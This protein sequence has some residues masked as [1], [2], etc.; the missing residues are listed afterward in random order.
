[1]AGRVQIIGA[2][3]ALA[4]FTICFYYI[5]VGGGEGASSYNYNYGLSAVSSFRPGHISV[6][7]VQNSCTPVTPG[8]MT[9]LVTGS[10][11]FVGFHTSIR[12]KEMGAGVL[13]LDNV[14]DYYP[15]AGMGGRRD[16]GNRPADQIDPAVE[17]KKK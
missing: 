4:L 3:I 11:G 2:V 6:A 8:Q 15:Q 14:N 13:G 9:V 5:G 12:L 17:R 1:M 7:K 10:A 16:F